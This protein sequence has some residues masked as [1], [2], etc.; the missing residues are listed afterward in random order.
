[1]DW[2]WVVD[3]TSSH[4]KREI[5]SQIFFSP[6]EIFLY[7]FNQTKFHTCLKKPIFYPEEKFLILTQ[8]NNFAYE[9][10]FLLTSKFDFL[11]KINVFLL[12]FKSNQFSKHQF[13]C[14]SLNKS[15]ILFFFKKKIK[16]KSS[17]YLLEKV[18]Y[19]QKNY[20]YLSEKLIFLKW[21]KNS[22][23]CIRELPIKIEGFFISFWNSFFPYLAFFIFR[24]IF[25]LCII[26]LLLFPFLL[27]KDFAIF[28][29]TFL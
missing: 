19:K 15:S 11:Y 20:M 10:K 1:M 14:T 21:K 22:Y 16:Q 4:S 8:K 25:I 29:N 9:N 26:I 5:S 24:E 23:T 13:S 18:I 28:H 27:G 6:K 2:S 7:L 17:L 3:N 12:A